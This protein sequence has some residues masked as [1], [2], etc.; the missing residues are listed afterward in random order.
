MFKGHV[1]SHI[2]FSVQ[3]VRSTWERGLQGG[4]GSA[5]LDQLQTF[6]IGVFLPNNSR[7][8]DYRKE[9]TNRVKN[10]SNKTELKS[11]NISH[12]IDFFT[13]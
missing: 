3:Q 4:L 10:L 9:F 12:I 6:R 8:S 2:L 1:M 13:Y 7:D 11:R 5:Q